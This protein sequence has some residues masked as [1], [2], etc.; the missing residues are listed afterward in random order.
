MALYT[1]MQYT[2][3]VL[4]ELGGFKTHTHTHTHTNVHTGNKPQNM[5][6]RGNSGREIVGWGD[7]VCVYVCVYMIKTHYTHARNS[8]RKDQS[9]ISGSGFLAKNKLITDLSFKR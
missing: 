8:Q 7:Q 1:H 4:S 5:K 2:A 3:T 6:L 9:L